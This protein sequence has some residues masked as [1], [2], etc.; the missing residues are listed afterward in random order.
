[1]RLHCSL[2]LAALALAQQAC[3]HAQSSHRLTVEEIWGQ[4]NPTGAPPQGIQWAPDGGRVTY[5][6]PDSDL[7]QVLPASG[8]STML[9]SHSKL[10]ALAASATNEK[11]K[12]HRER[13]GMASYLWAPDSKHI[14]FDS[15]GQ[16][17][18]YSLE[19]GTAIDIASTGAESGDDPKFAP[20][21]QLL[22]YVRGHNLYVHRFK[23][24]ASEVQLT[25]GHEETLLN[26]EVDWVYLEE[27]NVRSNY[28]WSPDSTRI[29]FLQMNEA[30]VPEYPITDWIPAA[31]DGRQTALSSTRR[32]EP[33]GARGRGQGAGRQDGLDEGADRRRL[34]TIFPDSD[35]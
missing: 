23:D 22:S 4:P 20:N 8:A 33:F 16:L 21:G 1:L 31:C 19:N 2:V 7:M 6:S 5:L 25:T 28:F 12:D 13:Y 29:A 17:F 3:L 14:L 30:N 24:Q 11:D 27:L 15:G 34:T 18:L 32:P 9:I 26:G 35:G 10:S